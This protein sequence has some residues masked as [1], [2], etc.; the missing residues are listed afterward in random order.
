MRDK[1]YQSMIELTNGKWSSSY[2]KRFA[3]SKLS[4]K[5]IPLYIK[6]FNITTEEICKEPR[7]FFH[8]S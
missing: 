5:I 1:I 7:R 8:I 3:Q 4:K 2:Y 6:Y